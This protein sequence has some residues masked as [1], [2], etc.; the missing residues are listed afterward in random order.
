MF[1]NIFIINGRK[2]EKMDAINCDC[3]NLIP[4]V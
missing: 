2:Q 4:T 3:G 1:I